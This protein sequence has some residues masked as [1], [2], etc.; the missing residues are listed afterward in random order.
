MWF[1]WGV[2]G[3]WR[4]ESGRKQRQ[5]QRDRH[6]NSPV[7]RDRDRQRQIETVKALDI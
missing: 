3:E 6:R 5:R 2:K 1:I 7:Q 4:N